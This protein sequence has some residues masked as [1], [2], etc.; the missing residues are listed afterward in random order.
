[1]RLIRKYF[2]LII[3]LV[4]SAL[5]HWYIFFDLKLLSSGDWV[6]FFNSQ[7]KT[8]LG[9]IL[10]ISSFDFGS[11]S[12]FSNNWIF[13]MLFFLSSHLFGFTWDI[14]TRVIFLIPIVF[15]TPIFSFLLFR[16]VFKNNLTA[17]FSACIYS[18]NT[19]FL[20]LQLDWIT[21]AFIWWLLPA[22]FLS[23]INYLETK[24]NKYL[25][26][27]ASLVFLGLVFELR[28]M[29]LVLV[30]LTLF[31]IIFLITC[32]EHIKEKVKSSFYILLS[33]ILGFLG[34]A[35]WI[36]PIKFSNIF[37]EVMNYASPNPFVSFY[38]IIDALTLH[39]YSWSYNFVMEPFIRQ[40][41]EWRHFL[42]PI[43]A[44][45]GIVYA[46]TQKIKIQKHILIFFMIVLPLF[47][48]LGNKN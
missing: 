38:N 6:F 37:G 16:K 25:I 4:I 46:I 21:Y 24:K 26:Y 39:M 45:L 36:I 8:T 3:L 15:L 31:Q 47:I 17:F 43:F 1:M 22:L 30:F 29:I 28:I 7:A 9:F 35:Y 23:M 48:F 33:I 18:F 12:A 19:F 13:Y 41:V 34:H 11:I 20:K 44:I 40:P 14:F 5:S 27:N 2:F 10:Y 42:I 32:P